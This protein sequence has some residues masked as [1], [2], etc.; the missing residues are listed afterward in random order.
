M[1]EFFN[2][3]S[4]RIMNNKKPIPAAQQDR[5]DAISRIQI[6]DEEKQA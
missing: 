2:E 3:N 6:E 1:A 4:D 5:E